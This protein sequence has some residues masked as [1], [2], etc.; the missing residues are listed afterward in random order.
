MVDPLR[1]ILQETAAQ[2]EAARRAREEIKV[3]TTG[4]GSVSIPVPS[5]TSPEVIEKVE[6]G[7][8]QT[9][10]E[11]KA[12]AGIEAA[13]QIQVQRDAFGN[14]IRSPEGTIMIERQIPSFLPTRIEQEQEQ[15]VE[16]PE[17]IDIPPPP[18]ILPRLPT[19]QAT[20]EVAEQRFIIPER[21]RRVQTGEGSFIE[22]IEPEQE[23]I[24]P[25]E[26]IEGETVVGRDDLGRIQE[27]TAEVIERT[28]LAPEPTPKTVFLPE[29]TTAFFE[30][31]VPIEQRG[32][33]TLLD[34]P[35]TR[36]DLLAFE[37]FTAQEQ[38]KGFTAGLITAPLALL[39]TVEQAASFLSD[40]KQK[41]EE[42]VK[43]LR[44]DPLKEGRVSP[45][46][47]GSFIAGSIVGQAALVPLVG[48]GAGFIADEIL[49]VPPSER[50]PFTITGTG[51][52]A[53]A[54]IE[55]FKIGDERFRISDE[56]L[57]TTRSEQLSF[58]NGRVR[59]SD[60]F[61]I[62]K[63]ADQFKQVKI[64]DELI[65][66]P[67]DV[68]ISG[69]EAKVTPAKRTFLDKIFGRAGTSEK[70]DV[71]LLLT[72]TIKSSS[73]LID[74]LDLTL[75]TGITQTLRIGKDI[76]GETSFGTGISIV[77]GERFF[78]IS[79]EKQL[80]IP[81]EEKGRFSIS[82]TLGELFET[83]EELL[84]S[85]FKIKSI[86]ISDKGVRVG[87]TGTTGISKPL[88]IGS[89]GA[90]LRV[91]TKPRTD[92][93]FSFGDAFSI[94]SGAGVFGD[95]G[96]ASELSLFPKAALFEQETQIFRTGDIQKILGT[97]VR[98][99]PKGRGALDLK[100]PSISISREALTSGTR[101]DLKRETRLRAKTRQ[102]QRLDIDTRQRLGSEF[103]LKSETS[104]TQRLGRLSGLGRQQRFKLL[105]E[106]Q[107]TTGATGTG[108][109]P[110]AGII[111]LGKPK[112][113]IGRT[114][115]RGKPQ[116]FTFKRGRVQRRVPLADLLSVQLTQAQRLREGKPIGFTQIASQELRRKFF[117]RTAGF[118][119]PTRELI[120]RRQRRKTRPRK[121]RKTTKK[122]LK[123][124]RRKSE[125]RF[126]GRS[127][128]V[129]FI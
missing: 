98:I 5:R 127:R 13:P 44:E 63:F 107:I 21:T 17:Q 126:F 85:Q 106:Q 80:I 40:P 77:E 58:G 70:V 39:G 113:E 9:I 59:I 100:Q 49:T 4:G 28:G 51:K 60:D 62:G 115:R 7:E 82:G 57:I 68:K 64:D 123:R 105:T 25:T 30:R 1:D 48:K 81:L 88:S 89:G 14:L 11:A 128:K 84:G 79:P 112:F 117:R 45:A 41:L 52:A 73:G 76:K 83:D 19:G 118:R 110:R 6:S 120:N 55:R 86:A 37:S 22:I 124:T 74:D 102:A 95:I 67:L 116:F 18:L 129:R 8:A 91:G 108:F 121:T 104:Q 29:T 3:G 111:N 66:F 78:D 31:E 122:K 61:K 42:T 54:T 32:Q 20:A 69:F 97:K 90:R 47:T 15:V 23:L 46:F 26:L 24:I 99:T 35:Q 125:N 109:I 43:L 93:G 10:S 33:Q 103:S 87:T 16:R 56:E 72:K 27:L 65:D 94:D 53:R 34:Q 36:T 75:D 12:L 101:F 38:L 50:T 119:V 92:V 96:R 114:R 71:D 2:R